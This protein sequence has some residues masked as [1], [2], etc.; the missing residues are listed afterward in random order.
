MTKG[1]T[2]VGW[3]WWDVR[4]AEVVLVAYRH[5]QLRSSYEKDDGHLGAEIERWTE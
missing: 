4:V 1:R 2:E 5:R 3:P